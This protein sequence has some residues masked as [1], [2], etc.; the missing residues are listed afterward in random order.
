MLFEDKIYNMER[1]IPS[2]APLF[3]ITRLWRVFRILGLAIFFY[4]LQT[5][6][7]LSDPT[8]VMWTQP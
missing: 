1:S 8:R 3:R 5:A 6:S 2:L 7:T 4:P